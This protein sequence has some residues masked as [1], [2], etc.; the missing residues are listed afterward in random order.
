MPAPTDSSYNAGV[1]TDLSQRQ[2]LALRPARAFDGLAPDVLVAPT[3]LIEDGRIVA[4]D[5]GRVDFGDDITVVEL[6]GCTVVPGL[7]D[8]HVHLCFDGSPD[9]VASL[10]DRDDASVVDS[11]VATARRQLR[12]GVTTV[13]DL[14]DRGFLS[15][16]FGRDDERP[17]PTVVSAGPPLTT[18]GG[19]CD[20]LGGGVD[21]G[22]EAAR[23]AV[24][25]HADRG[26][27]VIKVM[28]SGGFL[29]PGTAVEHTQFEPGVLGAIVDEAHRRGLPV[30]AH[31]HSAAAVAA[32]VDAGVDGIEHC[33]FLTPDGVQASP[34]LIERIARSRIVVGAT[35]GVVP[36]MSPPPEI[37]RILGDVLAAHAQMH[38]A[39]VTIVA[40][41][42]AGIGPPKPH[43]VLPHAAADLVGLGF[44]PAE[45]VRAMTA[46][47]ARVCG[48][49]D[50]KGRI[51]PGYDADLLAVVG[52]PLSD[53]AVLHDV[54]SV[55][56]AGR[57][58]D[59]EEL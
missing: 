34:E 49:G 54:D 35:V 37:A 21:A 48:L 45:A 19:H 27:E 11:M 44:S 6:P 56:L 22:V 41:T 26:V 33:S 20:F 30:V 55:Y 46:D 24:A 28:A 42:D 17:L 58:L 38:A 4:V 40:G 13:R 5:R 23:A 39:G 36:G 59:L 31:A 57:R 1:R 3:I 53:L 43:G 47:A 51:A 52:D 15:V 32:A 8:T 16:G 7:I 18:V 10:A 29:T 9:P 2:R 25:D 14:G 12:A 50:S